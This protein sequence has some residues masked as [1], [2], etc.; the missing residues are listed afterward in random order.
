MKKII[1]LAQSLMQEIERYNKELIEIERVS[2]YRWEE[3]QQL[4]QENEQLKALIEEM[5]NCYNCSNFCDRNVDCS[6][7]CVRNNPTCKNK[8]DYWKMKDIY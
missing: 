2:D 5:K 8:K 7:I 3:N 4:K 1:T 6:S